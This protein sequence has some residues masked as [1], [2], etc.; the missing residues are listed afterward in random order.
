MKNNFYLLL[1]TLLIVAAGCKKTTTDPVVLPEGKFTGTFVRLHLNPITNKLDT[2]TAN[3]IFNISAATGY[4]ITGDTSVFHAGSHGSMVVDGTFAQFSDQT[5]TPNTPLYPGK[6]HL[7]GI[8][9]YSYNGKNFNFA[10][11]NDT[12]GFYYNLQRQ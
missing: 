3:L 10:I 11:N 6:V 7:A 8:Y 12:L 4:A 5:L 9:N 2:A 1:I